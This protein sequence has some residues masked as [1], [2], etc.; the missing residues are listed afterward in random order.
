MKDRT[1]ES[2]NIS[3]KKIVEEPIVSSFNFLKYAK[4]IAFTQVV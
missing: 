1:T 4:V 2:Y 3:T